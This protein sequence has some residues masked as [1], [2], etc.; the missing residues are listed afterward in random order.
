MSREEE[1]EAKLVLASSWWSVGKAERA[2]LLGSESS[3]SQ[4]PPWEALH[5]GPVCLGLNL[6]G[7]GGGCGQ[8]SL[9]S[10]G[11]WIEIAAPIWAMSH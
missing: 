1:A 5:A 3:P 4:Y 10:G 8:G 9:L 7:P 6:E 2:V 11:G